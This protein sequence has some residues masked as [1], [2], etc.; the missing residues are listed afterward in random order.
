MLATVALTIGG[1][2]PTD[3]L[4]ALLVNLFFTAL[5]CWAAARCCSARCA[6]GIGKLLGLPRGL[7][8]HSGVRDRVRRERNDSE[9]TLAPEGARPRPLP[10][11]PIQRKG[12][13]AGRG[14]NMQAQSVFR[15]PASAKQGRDWRSPGPLAW[16][17]GPN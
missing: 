15:A 4:G 13:I 8:R 10:G 5:L 12:P 11:G 17:D 3:L 6:G 9:P 2:V 14:H 7:S 1:V 16:A